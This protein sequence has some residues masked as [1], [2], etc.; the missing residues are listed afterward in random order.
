MPDP[1]DHHEDDDGGSRGKQKVRRDFD[2]PDCTANN[3]YDE[4]VRPGE[5]VRCFY[6]GMEYRV[7]ATRDGRVR[8][9]AM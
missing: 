9:R 2:C 6:C 4:G 3:P 1:L 7:E 5:E 8:F